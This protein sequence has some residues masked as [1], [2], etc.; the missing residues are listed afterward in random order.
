MSRFRRF[1]GENTNKPEDTGELTNIACPTKDGHGIKVGSDVYLCLKCNKTYHNIDDKAYDERT[2]AFIDNEVKY[3]EVPKNADAV[4]EI[5]RIK[6]TVKD[7]ESNSHK[8]CEALE[9][10]EKYIYNC[11]LGNFQISARG[12]ERYCMT[13]P[14]VCVLKILENRRDA[15]EPLI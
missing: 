8:K 15:G 3:L 12:I 6:R 9:K 2:F 13:N 10:E 4:T 14:D 1:V 5:M 7:F 11:K